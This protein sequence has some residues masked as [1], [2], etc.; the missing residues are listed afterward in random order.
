MPYCA[1]WVYQSLASNRMKPKFNKVFLIPKSDLIVRLT[2]ITPLETLR[3]QC[4]CRNFAERCLKHRA[5][6]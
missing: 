4:S 3:H 1:C 2:K 6:G 5:I